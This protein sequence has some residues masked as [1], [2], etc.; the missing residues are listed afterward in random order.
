M[1]GSIG[2][3]IQTDGRQGISNLRS[4]S[5]SE[6]IV[7]LTG[8]RDELPQLL[9]LGQAGSGAAEFRSWSKQA[10]Q[11]FDVSAVRLPGRETRGREAYLPRCRRWSTK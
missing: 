1:D 6:T 3:V 9:C 5:M 4:E 11:L 8:P 2:R 10:E 7:H